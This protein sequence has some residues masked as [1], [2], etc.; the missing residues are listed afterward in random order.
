MGYPYF[1]R[2]LKRR[3]KVRSYFP[4]GQILSMQFAIMSTSQS[5]RKQKAIRIIQLLTKNKGDEL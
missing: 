4:E 3:Y 1:N 5:L 2:K